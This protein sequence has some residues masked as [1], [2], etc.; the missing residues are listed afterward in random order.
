MQYHTI[1]RLGRL[2]ASVTLPEHLPLGANLPPGSFTP[3]PAAPAGTAVVLGEG[4][5][6]VISAPEG[7]RWRPGAEMTGGGI[8]IDAKIFGENDL[9]VDPE[10][11]GWTNIAPPTDLAPGDAITG[12]D[13]AKGRWT[14]RRETAAQKAA[15]EAAALAAARETTSVKLFQLIRALK[16]MTATREGVE[17][18]SYMEVIEAARAA[19]T[20]PETIWDALLYLDPVPRKAEAV[21][22]IAALFQLTEEQTDAVFAAAGAVP[23]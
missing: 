18:K 7:V 22:Q 8:S 20:L 2:A 6:A 21:G 19:G 17:G 12:F 16:T 14:V 1:D 5:W 4:G 13:R 3:P 9:G 15:R 10:A 23:I 11:D